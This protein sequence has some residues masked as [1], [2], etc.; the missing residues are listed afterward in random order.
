MN[1]SAPKTPFSTPLHGNTRETQLRI[2]NIVS[3]PKKRPPLL[4][5]ALM[6]AVA[7]FCGNLVSC[8]PAQKTPDPSLPDQSLPGST[9]DP[10]LPDDLRSQI[11]TRLQTLGDG[12]FAQLLRQD[13]DHA[14]PADGFQS[15]E[16]WTWTDSATMAFCAL[17]GEEQKDCVLV[18]LYPDT[19]EEE[20]LEYVL[21]S[22][23]LWNAIVQNYHHDGTVDQEMLARV[24]P[25]IDALTERLCR[26]MAESGPAF[27]VTSGE[28]V[29]FNQLYRYDNL[30]FSPG[31]AYLYSLDIAL[32]G[33]DLSQIFMAGGIW[34]DSEGRLRDNYSIAYA[35]ILEEN[36][37][38]TKTVFLSGDAVSVWGYSEDGQ[39]EF[40]LAT[41]SV[42]QNLDDGGTY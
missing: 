30:S 14:L 3:G 28:V 25:Q 35:A 7:L 6:C 31:T 32:S 9:P 19:P 12:T 10:A 8:Q 5:V 15:N 18:Y 42:L 23:D 33:A 21:L 27:A 36:G 13:M 26:D 37:E 40:R 2:R 11:E 20:R 17:A 16:F 1:L 4:L 22:P 41:E 39:D 24:R 38:I 34:V 29:D